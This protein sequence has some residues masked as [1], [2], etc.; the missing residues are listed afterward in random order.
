[1]ANIVHFVHIVRTAN[2]ASTPN[3][4][5]IANSKNIASTVDI[6]TVDIASTVHIATVDIE[7]TVDI[8]N[9]ASIHSTTEH[10]GPAE[11]CQKRVSRCEP[12]ILVPIC[13]ESVSRSR[14]MA[15]AFDRFL[16]RLLMRRW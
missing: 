10:I 9:M 1:M 6:A 5:N 13:H 3:M 2:I 12:G 4:A 7:S 8:A 16:G 11:W 15:K 14:R